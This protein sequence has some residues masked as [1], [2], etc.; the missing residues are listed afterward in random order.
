MSRA[1]PI[2]VCLA[3]AA[4][5]PS[6]RELFDPVASVVRDRTGVTPSWRDGEPS[7][8][9]AARVKELLAAPLTAD[10]AAELAI[11]ND[12]ALQ[13]E[14]VAL[15]VAGGALAAA[16]TPKNP[17]V[18]AILRYPLEGGGDPRLE[19]H[20]IV[21]LTDL[22]AVWARSS[23]ADADVR[24]ARH[25]AA[26]H[27]IAHAAAARA[28]FA[29]AAAATQ[30]VTLRR[31]IA[32]AAD[33]SAELAQALR[34][35]GNMTELDLTRELLFEEE[36]A[37]EVVEAQDH[38]TAARERVNTLLGLTGAETGWT[39]AEG[40]PAP[41]ET[42][43]PLDQLEHDAVARSLD[44]EAHRA[45]LEAAGERVGVA[46]LES[47]LPDV[48]VGVAYEQAEHGD[49]LGP[50]L[51]LGVPLFDWGQGRRATAW[52]E[53]RGLRQAYA[54]AAVALR[55]TARVARARLEGAHA[56]V[57]RLRKTV[58]PLRDRLAAE[59][60]KHYNAMSLS[61]FELLIVRREQ[62]DA[63][64][65]YVDALR[66]YW[67]ADAAVTALRAGATPAMPEGGAR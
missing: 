62:I 44:L 5:A 39:P 23:A 53:L 28:A 10:A 55:A 8:A 30:T 7:A 35:S 25:E 45:R 32:D 33:A 50:A 16:R 40:L 6:R 2:S 61:P 56:R 67:I 66:D 54:A 21:S 49:T 57:T 31:A 34:S 3:L 13:A 29:E 38:A 18:D 15:G 1:V 51:R 4:C 19:L 9:V 47:F 63:E 65:R 37:L 22:F 58:L 17:E 24:A 52:A 60:L 48:G 41:P 36:A 64:R 11:L 42:L 27:A 12:A 14:L 43:P 20:A 46:R 26:A 59:S